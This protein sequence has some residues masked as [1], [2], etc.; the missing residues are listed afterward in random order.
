[1][2]I[3]DSFGS[4]EIQFSSSFAHGAGVGISGRSKPSYHSAQEIV[5]SGVVREEYHCAMFVDIEIV[6]LGNTASWDTSESVHNGIHEFS[7]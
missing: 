5:V 3:E 2:W 6:H 4:N 7:E 1:M